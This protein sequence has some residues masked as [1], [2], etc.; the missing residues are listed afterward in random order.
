MFNMWFP[1]I[2][3]IE[4]IGTATK[5]TKEGS[6]GVLMF[7]LMNL[8]GVLFAYYYGNSPTD[9]QVLDEQDTQDY[10]LGAFIAIPL[11]LFFA[12]RIYRG[13]GW[14]VAGLVLA[15]F[16]LEIGFKIVGGTTNIFWM[17]AYANVAILIFNGLRACW[18]LRK[19]RT[20][21]TE[22]SLDHP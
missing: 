21:N 18:W 16:I 4:D 19:A 17:I 12:Y 22:E 1:K 15:W 20:K 14:F 6:V 9:Q 2:E 8:A 11:L 3:K 13:K 7:A 5:L 10:V